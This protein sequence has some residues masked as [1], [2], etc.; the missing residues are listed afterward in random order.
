[1]SAYMNRRGSI[2]WA[3]TLIAVGALFLFQNFNPAVHPWQLIAKYWPILII[4][5]GLSKLFDYL[6]AEAHPD[7][8][9]PPL[10]TGSEIVLLVLIL[11]VGTI[12]SHIVLHPWREWPSQFGVNVD[13]QDWESLFENSYTFTKTVSQPVNANPHIVI[14]DQ[15]GDLQIQPTDQSTIEAVLKENI[16]ADNEDDAKK[17]SDQLKVEVVEEAGHYLLRSN[18][19]SLPHDGRNVM[20]D[21]SLRVPKTSSFDITSERGDVALSGLQGNQSVTSQHGDVRISTVQGQVEIHK[22]GDTTEVNDVKGNV[23]LDG[24]GTDVNMKGVAGTVTV[25][26]DFTGDVEFDN[27]S[28]TLRYTSSRTDLTAEKLSG[29]LSMDMGSL[30]ANGVD[31]PI[32]ISTKQKDITLEGFKH[33]VKIVNTN[34]DVQL[35]TPYA[36]THPIEVDL[37]KGEIQLSVP[38]SSGFQIDATSRNGDVECDF[39]GLTVNRQGDTPSIKGTYGKGGAEIR[40]STAYGTIHLTRASAANASPTPS[41]TTQSSGS[42][43]RL[44]TIPRPHSAPGPRRLTPAATL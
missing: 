29:R 12:V 42:E 33:I 15:R 16:R 31:G 9:A 25:N 20:L 7:T 40:L 39:P 5:W 44:T 14:D 1:M 26:G 13:E 11:I 34:G 24:R 6:Q 37:N 4:F 22:T 8:I 3:L 23:N 30:D 36:V 28:Q 21:I 32:D 27:V 10:F 38:P 18:R 2:F 17:V 43:T 35:S 19:R 41:R